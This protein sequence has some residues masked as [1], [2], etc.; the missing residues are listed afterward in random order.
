MVRELFVGVPASSLPLRGLKRLHSAYVIR[1]LTRRAASEAAISLP[2][3]ESVARTVLRE[4][5]PAT[6]YEAAESPSA[7]KVDERVSS[8]APGRSEHVVA[9]TRL[10]AEPVRFSQLDDDRAVLPDPPLVTG[11]Y[12]DDQGPPIQLPP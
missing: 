10:R 1:G 8:N 6:L 4:D 7:T 9:P 3:R 12:E 11:M 5:E 2:K